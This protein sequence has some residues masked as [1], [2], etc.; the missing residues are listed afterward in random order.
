MIFKLLIICRLIDTASALLHGSLKCVVPY[1][2][3]VIVPSIINELELEVYS[4]SCMNYS[5]LQ[6]VGL[7]LTPKKT[8]ANKMGCI[9][10]LFYMGYH[11]W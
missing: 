2:M 3:Y 7:A 11:Y 10:W 9:N 1:T 4:V 8:Y 6:R 5:L